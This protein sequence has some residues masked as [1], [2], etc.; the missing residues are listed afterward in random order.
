MMYKMA[1]AAA[2]IATLAPGCA[3]T[4][5]A[6][7]SNAPALGGPTAVDPRIHDTIANGPD[8]CG[9]RLD[10]GPLRNRVPPCPRAAVPASD[11]GTPVRTDDHVVFPWVEHYYARWPCEFSQESRDVPNTPRDWARLARSAPTCGLP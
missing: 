11:P 6:G 7:L 4:V 2:L 10:P 1:L 8:S 3:H 5:Q 9:R